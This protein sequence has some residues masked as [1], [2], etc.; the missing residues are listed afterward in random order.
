VARVRLS[1]YP[2]FRRTGDCN[3]RLKLS[4]STCSYYGLDPKRKNRIQRPGSAAP[5]LTKKYLIRAAIHTD[6][7]SCQG[8]SPNRVHYRGQRAKSKGFLVQDPRS[9]V[10]GPRAIALRS[11]PHPH[12]IRH[13][14]VDK[15]WQP[16]KRPLT[17]FHSITQFTATC[18]GQKRWHKHCQYDRRSFKK[19]RGGWGNGGSAG[20]RK[21]ERSD[22]QSNN[23]L[24]GMR[25]RGLRHPLWC[26]CLQR[27]KM[28]QN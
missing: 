2:D 10:Q 6:C 14:R 17:W 7:Q 15:F 5:L 12:A 20:H 4:C 27:I 19:L 13:S 18:A 3:R 1:S 23:K 26:F 9:K 25:Q 8:L 21:T 28:K 24:K 16:K 22:R 11:L